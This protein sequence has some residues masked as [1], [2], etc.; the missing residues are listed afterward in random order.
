MDTFQKDRVVQW[1]RRLDEER[2]SRR[3][4]FDPISVHVGFVVDTVTLGQVFHRVF[5][6]S[7]YYSINA[8]QSSSSTCCC[9]QL[10]NWAKTGIF[11]KSNVLSEIG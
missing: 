8:V 3:H 9:Y 1:F 2:L 11:L 7:I 10:Y 4:G 5:R 6:F